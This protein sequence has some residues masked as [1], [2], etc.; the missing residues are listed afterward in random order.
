M[1]EKLSGNKKDPLKAAVFSL[2]IVQLLFIILIFIIVMITKSFIIYIFFM[3]ILVFMF[4]FL[5]QII[6]ILLCIYYG[7]KRM[8]IRLRKIILKRVD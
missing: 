8:Q 3:A 5:Y 2:I 1:D 7:I 6:I 4:V